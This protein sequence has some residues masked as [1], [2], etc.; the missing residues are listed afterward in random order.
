MYEE[1]KNSLKRSARCGRKVIA[2][3]KSLDVVRKYTA[4]FPTPPHSKWVKYH[5]FRGDNLPVDR[6]WETFLW[7]TRSNLSLYIKT[8][9]VEFQIS[10]PKKIPR[11]LISISSLFWTLQTPRAST[12]QLIGACW[13]GNNEG[14]FAPFCVECSDWWKFIKISQIVSLSLDPLWGGVALLGLVFWYWIWG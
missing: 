11:R 12:H 8:S 6:I 13:G 14:W 4:Y 1:Y 2:I 9:I 7:Q 5:F 10:P 3:H